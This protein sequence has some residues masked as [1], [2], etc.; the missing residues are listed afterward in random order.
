MFRKILLTLM[1][2][3]ITLPAFAQSSSLTRGWPDTDFTNTSVDLDGIMSGGPGKDGI[4]ALSSVDLV[5]V[6]E[7]EFSEREPVLTVEMDGVPARAYPIR[8]LTWHEIANDVIGDVPVAVTFCPLCNSALVFDRRLD[9]EVLEFGVSGNLM[10]SNMVMFDRQTE[11]WWLQ[12]T[13]KG[14]VG[15]MNGKQLAQIVSWM[16]SLGEFRA[17]N[18]NGEVMAQ[19]ANFNR[20]YGANPYAGY[21]SSA[22]PFLYRGENPPF[23]ISPLARVVT[24]GN[25][26]W[27]L[28]RLSEVEEITE[29]GVRIVWKSGMASALGARR[30]S[31]ARDIGSIRVYDAETG[32]DVIHDV[33][34]AFAFHAF[35]PD[36]EWMLGE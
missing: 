29:A 21:D 2:S 16:E 32:E 31:D 10:A 19:P 26:A 28:E 30:I 4:P 14:I 18:P 23:G 15:D 8:Y 3:A 34:F 12:F 9:G 17:R 6:G 25:R 11:S 35:K 5:P 27:P 22:Q 1:L 7:V 24:V 36:G 13:G 33:A 20:Q